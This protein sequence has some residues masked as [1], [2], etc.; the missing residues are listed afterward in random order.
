MCYI[1]YKF[2]HIQTRLIVLHTARVMCT[3]GVSQWLVIK[4]KQ[5]KGAIDDDAYV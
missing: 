4:E 3:H 5:E 1:A 2:V